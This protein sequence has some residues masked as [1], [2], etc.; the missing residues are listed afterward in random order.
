MN[1]ISSKSAQ[2]NFGRLL[3]DAQRGPVLITRHDR[4]V[5]VV[6]SRERFE[7]LEAMEDAI[8]AARARVA[9]QGGFVGTEAT[10]EFIERVLSAD[11]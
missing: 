2:D 1:T 11:A 8:W 3:D 7:E 5:A 6:V 9:A 4:A 10:A